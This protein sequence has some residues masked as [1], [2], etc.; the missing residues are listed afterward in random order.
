M[1]QYL[2][3]ASNEY[4]TRNSKTFLLLTVAGVSLFLNER[5]LAS[6]QLR[7]AHHNCNSFVIKL[8]FH[9]NTW[10]NCWYKQFCDVSS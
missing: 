9:C 7:I 1:R 2:P 5:L 3:A 6:F 4:R 8:S 10:V